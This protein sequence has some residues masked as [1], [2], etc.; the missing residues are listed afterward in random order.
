M[1]PHVFFESLWMLLQ[2]AEFFITTRWQR[3]N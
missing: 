1:M 2:T 3:C